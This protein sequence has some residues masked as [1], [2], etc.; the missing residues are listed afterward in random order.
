MFS[1]TI[2]MIYWGILIALMN[3][4]NSPG[5]AGM[6]MI[7]G[8]VIVCVSNV[9]ITAITTF[10]LH[11]ITNV[12]KKSH[13]ILIILP[14]GILIFNIH[15]LLCIIAQFDIIVY[16]DHQGWGIISLVLHVISWIL[17]IT[18]III[19]RRHPGNMH[20][21]DSVRLTEIPDSRD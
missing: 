4:L 10:I 16:G 8:L 18:E 11:I 14:I 5:S 19:I 1:F 6:L 15:G 17:A 2:F 7:V 9:T 20:D 21:H 13:L 12:H 3:P